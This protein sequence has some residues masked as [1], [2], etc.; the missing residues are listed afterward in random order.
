[1]PLHENRYFPDWDGANRTFVQ[2]MHCIKPRVLWNG[3]SF[4]IFIF[5]VTTQ[6]LIPPKFLGRFNLCWQYFW[7]TLEQYVDYEELDRIAS[8]GFATDEPVAYVEL[9]MEKYLDSCM[10]SNIQKLFCLLFGVPITIMLYENRTYKICVA[11]EDTRVGGN[12][13]T[14]SE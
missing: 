1:M 3:K 6:Y 12:D 10:P 11:K 4:D 2:L 14:K 7:K 5:P 8:E 13:G 9:E